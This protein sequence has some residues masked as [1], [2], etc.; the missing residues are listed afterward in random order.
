MGRAHSRPDRV[1]LPSGGEIPD[2]LKSTWLDPILQRHRTAFGHLALE[3]KDWPKA[4]KEVLTSLQAK[5]SHEPVLSQKRKGY[6]G[7]HTTPRSMVRQQQLGAGEALKNKQR[8]KLILGWGDLGREK[9]E[10]E[11]NQIRE[12]QDDW[13]PKSSE[14]GGGK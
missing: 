7:P 8:G 10:V 9:G 2:C 4:L 14:V 11:R 13:K 5:A 3:G 1:A 12:G 6:C